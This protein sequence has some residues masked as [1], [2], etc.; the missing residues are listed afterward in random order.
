MSI[1][2]LVTECFCCFFRLLL[3]CNFDEFFHVLYLFGTTEDPAAQ[4]LAVSLSDNLPC[5]ID[6]TLN[7]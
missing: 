1:V 4:A 2:S 7:P 5:S 6:T 3:L